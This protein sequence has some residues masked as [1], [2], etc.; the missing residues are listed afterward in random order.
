ML[1]LAFAVWTSA[2]CYLFYS[3]SSSSSNDVFFRNV[4]DVYDGFFGGGGGGGD[5]DDGRRRRG[6]SGGGRRSRRRRRD[7]TKVVVQQGDYSF[8][9]RSPEEIEVLRERHAREAKAALGTAAGDFDP[10][11]FKRDSGGKRSKKKKRRSATWSGGGE[12][13]GVERLGRGCSE[14]DWHAY[15]FP[16]CNEIHEIDLRGAVRHHR[17]DDRREGGGGGSEN[18]RDGGLPW[19]F[20]G[21]GLW[22]DVFS[23]DPREE[24]SAAPPGGDSSSP[25]RPPAVLKV[26]KSEHVSFNE[27][28]MICN[29]D[30]KNGPRAPI[31]SYL[32]LHSMLFA[33]LI[34]SSFSQ[35]I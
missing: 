29:Y 10:D 1:F 7:A 32:T 34:L 13:V 18:S 22:R 9:E 19:G 4:L 35:A 16:N 21:N 26:M 31:F 5:D 25:P 23:C 24:A 17:R 27:L 11:D 30:G 6:G 28:P 15:H 33:I 8:K 20:V 2:Q 3:W 14:L 12:G